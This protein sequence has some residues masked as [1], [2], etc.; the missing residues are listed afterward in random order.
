MIEQAILKTLA[1]R[2]IFSYPLTAGEVHRFLIK[3]RATEAAVGKT[4]AKMTSEGLIEEKDG[5]FFLPGRKEVV[6]LRQKREV[7]SRVKLRKIKRYA[8][9]L[10]LVPWVRAVFA[11]GAV[12]VGN[13][14][15]DA[16]LDILVITAPRRLWLSRLLVFGILIALGIK[17]KA[18]CP[19]GKDKVCPNMFFDLDHLALP[20]SEQ[21]LYTAHEA[22]QVKVLWERESIH[23]RFLAENSWIK[24]F[25]PNWRQKSR[26]SDMSL[27]LLRQDK[28]RQ[29]K[30]PSVPFYFYILISSFVSIFDFLERIAYQS[31]LRYMA[32]RRTREVVM[33]GRIL[34][35]SV[36]L[37]AVILRTYHHRLHSIGS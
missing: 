22:V 36:D 1:Y 7:V 28:G 32:K 27:R 30:T 6:S 29:R 12:A 9:F 17:R 13:A 2:D 20:K 21:N 14:D 26:Y 16:D 15:D 25:L 10:R 34:F 33:P 23:Q 31:Q 5:F 37:P 35:H 4:L 19:A 3:E 11:T 18:K 8:G 24:E